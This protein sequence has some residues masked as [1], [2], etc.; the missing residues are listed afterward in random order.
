MKK[1][2]LYL[3]AMCLLCGCQDKKNLLNMLFPS[4]MAIDYRNGE[5]MIAFQ[6]D[7]L[8]TVAKSE[9]ES[10]SQQTT[11]L[12]A[13]DQGPSIEK[14][15]SKIE[16]TQRSMIN[17]S[18]V[19]S[20]VLLPG[21][22]NQ[23]I[24]KDICSYAAF[25]PE[26]RMD[27]AVYYS[28]E[29][30]KKIYSTNFQVS[31]SQLYTLTNSPEFKK[32]SM[33]LQSVNLMQFAKAINDIDITLELPVLKVNDK[34]DS[35]ITGEGESEQKVYDINQL[36]YI[37]SSKDFHK[38]ID[39]EHLKGIQ[40]I[41]THH[42][43]ID[44]SLKIDNEMVNAYST[45]VY[46]WTIYDPK[47]Q[48]YHLKGKANLVVTRDT[49]LRPLEEIKPYIEKAIHDEIAHTYQYGL[50]NKI[51]VYNLRYKSML[52]QNDIAPTLDNFYDELKI[53]LQIKGSYISSQ[54]H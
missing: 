17:L 40:W 14:A 25:N 50:E 46:A 53:D 9:L 20:L 36:I 52:F 32:V 47:S 30:P 42:N 37:D 5:Y 54:S 1:I 2:I 13:M 44:V 22:M 6:I 31:R 18:H 12:I 4:S 15:I 21:T 45:A 16:E 3:L 38:T 51:D 39:F 34:L 7:N 8:N 43:N 49:A 48:S 10:S 24:Q 35:Y 23:K 19:R 11:L 28:E 33:I 41:E 26:L 27:T 29:D